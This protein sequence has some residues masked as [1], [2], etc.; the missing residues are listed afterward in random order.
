MRPLPR[1]VPVAA[2]ALVAAAGYLGSLGGGFVFDDLRHIQQ[3]ALIRDL[4]NYLG[5]SAGYAAMPNRYLGYL[6]FALN[7]RLA[8]LDV[9][10]FRAVNVAIHSANAMLVYALVTLAFRAPGLAGS[11]LA[12]SSGAVAFTAAALFGAHPLQTEAVT[13][14]VQRFTSLVALFYLGAVVLYARWRLQGQDPG[15]SRAARAVSYLPVLAA[16]ALATK[17]KESAFTLPFAA[18]LLEALLLAGPLRPRLAGLLPLLATA[19]LIPLGLLASPALPGLGNVEVTGQGALTPR[20]YLITQITVLPAY[21]RL[22]LLPLGQNVDH[23]HP[24]HRSL[25]E[26]SV[27]LSL[28]LLLALGGI[29]VK[30]ASVA[31]RDPERDPALRLVGFG[32]LWFFVAISVESSLVPLADVMVER[33]AYLP[34]VGLFVA[35]SAAGALLLRRAVPAGWARWLVAS[36]V[37]LAVALAAATWA[38]NAVWK[39]EISLWA[40]AAARSPRK[41]RPHLNLGVASYERGRVDDAIREFQV[42]LQ[43]QP[44]LADAHTNLGIAYLAKGLRAEG[45]QEMMLGA[46]LRGRPERPG[47]ADR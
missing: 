20:E 37:V 6:T 24:V 47:G 11:A 33:R 34:S 43:L 35:A 1:A 27:A 10:W 23:D 29:A 16:A 5:S 17:T 26:P 22:L 46:S 45:V 19:L 12:R 42:V 36:S 44:D 2:V 4:G 9:A 13:Y 28:A 15:R 3:N 41:P 39:D 14:V 25:L 38:R 30:L 21:L 8:G 31:G 32:I 18:A 7:Y 40:D